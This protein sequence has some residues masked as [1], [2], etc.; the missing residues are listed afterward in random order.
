MHSYVLAAM[1]YEEKH[2]QKSAKVHPQPAARKLSWPLILLSLWALASCSNEPVSHVPISTLSSNAEERQRWPILK[3]TSEMLAVYPGLE[4]LEKLNVVSEL[5]RQEL[6]RI[7]LEQWQNGDYSRLDWFTLTVRLPPYYPLN[8]AEWARYESDTDF[9][10]NQSPIDTK[11][12]TTWEDIYPQIKRNFLKNE[13]RTSVDIRYLEYSELIAEMEHPKHDSAIFDDKEIKVLESSVVNF[14]QAYPTAID[15]RDIDT[16]QQMTRNVVRGFLQ[17]V[18]GSYGWTLEQTSQ[19]LA[20]ERL[21]GSESAAQTVQSIGDYIGRKGELPP[22]LIPQERPTGPARWKSLDEELTEFEPESNSVSKVVNYYRWMVSRRRYRDIGLGL[23]EEGSDSEQEQKYA[24]LSKTLYERASYPVDPLSAAFEL[25]QGSASF[26]PILN[27]D[28]ESFSNW[29]RT[30]QNLHASVFEDLSTSESAKRVLLFS[31]VWDGVWNIRTGTSS[32]FSDVDSVLEAIHTLYTEYGDVAATLMLSQIIVRD[33]VQYGLGDEELVAFIEPMLSYNSPE[34]SDLAHG[35][36][37]LL[38]ARQL[39]V[40]IAAHTLK[41]EKFTLSELLGQIVLVDHWATTCASCIEAMPLLHDIYERNKDSGFEVISI[42]YDG[43]SN[44]K[45]VERIEKELGL[46]W[47]TVDGEGQWEEISKKYGYQGFPQY[48]LLNRDGTLYAGT[49]EVDMGRN[50]EALLE[51]MLAVE[52][53]EK[54]ASTVH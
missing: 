35:A 53:A 22:S 11:R 46:T 7:I 52:A 47:L 36:I 48:M 49:G 21:R 51:E 41:G 14:V 50:L 3:S 5:S 42:A 1:P 8:V 39:P 27:E 20:D 13:A 45:L 33:Q 2:R 15:T 10:N 12:S 31:D 18:T 9:K 40:E 6:R 34:L 37:N 30:Y 24:W 29:V 54:E 26:L 32:R 16:H 28:S 23:W 38:K 44:R 25:Q 17:L 43:T 4:G 19:F